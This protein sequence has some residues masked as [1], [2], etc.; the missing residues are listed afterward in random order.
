MLRE[1]I[2]IKEMTLEEYIRKRLVQRRK[3]KVRT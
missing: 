2:E 3:A 1:S